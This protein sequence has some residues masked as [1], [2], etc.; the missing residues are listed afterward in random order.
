MATVE[1]INKAF[2]EKGLHIELPLDGSFEVKKVN[3][4]EKKSWPG[5]VGV[6][7]NV[8]FVNERGKVV[9]DLFYCEGV[10]ERESKKVET[11]AREP[12]KA[13]LLPLREDWAFRDEEEAK[14]CLRE[15]II[16]L[17]EDKGYQLAEK[18][19]ADIYL[20]KEGRGFFFNLA[21][22]CGHEALLRV[23]DL[24]ELRRRQGAGADYGLVVPAFQ[25]SLGV[26]LRE[27][28]IW[29]SRNAEFFSAHRIGVY[30]VDNKDLNR[31]YAFTIYPKA[32]ELIPYF[33]NITP[34]WPLVRSRYVASRVKQK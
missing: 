29:V 6:L 22:R 23:K 26:P 21:A 2:A 32:R 31:V 16:H 19:G 33:V 28:E 4:L 8:T 7:L 1:E 14:A 30:A 20:E 34:Q 12:L 25:E 9:N 17:L 27:Q 5:G 18:P 15:A 13:Q 24:V 3:I 11:K 10:V